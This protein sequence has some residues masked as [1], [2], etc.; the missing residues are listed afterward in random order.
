MA[1][2]VRVAGAAELD[3]GPGGRYVAGRTW[4]H[5]RASPALWGV[6][7]FGRPDRADSE[8]LV[9]SLRAELGAAPHRSL[10]D[11]ARVDGADAGAFEALSAYVQANRAA[12][13]ERVTQLGLVRPPGMQ[14]A[15]I[16]GFF[17]VTP[18]PYP[19]QLF[20]D[21][22]AALR[23][24]GEPGRDA[25]T[26]ALDA[27]VRELTDEGPLLGSLRAELRRRLLDP[28]A[29]ALDL[30]PVSRALAIS[31]RTLQ[32]RLQEIDTTFQHEVTQARLAEVTRRLLDTDDALTTIALDLG[33]ASPQHL[34]A[35]FKK[36]HGETP[37]AWRKRRRGR[38]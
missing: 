10:V 21:R 32:R 16:A 33:F 38:P 3:G 12:L 11:G 30:E 9:R 6:V 27:C 2:L 13:A 36:T 31:D 35:T 25:L 23:W 1:D 7:L 5:F 28:D 17:G 24:L 8:A 22:D 34:S 37:S 4:I 26:V 20:E 14:G 19:V 15:V 29:G 18:P